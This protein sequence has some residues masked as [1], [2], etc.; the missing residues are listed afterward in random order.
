MN[1]WKLT[2]AYKLMN[3]YMYQIDDAI[4]GTHSLFSDRVWEKNEKMAFV[5]T[6]TVDKYWLNL[7]NYTK[8]IWT[9]E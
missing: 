6:G 9:L 5:W 7:E 8:R 3:R 2:Y 4:N 1:K